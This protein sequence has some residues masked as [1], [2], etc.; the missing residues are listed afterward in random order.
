MEINLKNST[1]K[2]FVFFE[3]KFA[4]TIFEYDFHCH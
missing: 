4:C 3:F 2:D 1:E